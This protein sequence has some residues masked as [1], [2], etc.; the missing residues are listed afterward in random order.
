MKVQIHENEK[1]NLEEIFINHPDLKKAKIKKILIGIII[2]ELVILFIILNYFL[3]EFL[4]LR[5]LKFFA[6]TGLIH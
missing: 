6:T 5:D 1:Y 3:N 2:I 4:F